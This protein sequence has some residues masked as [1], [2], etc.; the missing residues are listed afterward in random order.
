MGWHGEGAHAAKCGRTDSARVNGP[1][2]PEE[3]PVNAASHLLLFLGQSSALSP[4]GSTPIPQ[5]EEGRRK[6]N[7]QQ[8]V[9]QQ[10]AQQPRGHTQSRPGTG[11]RLLSSFPSGAHPSFPPALLSAAPGNILQHSP[12]SPC[13]PLHLQV[14]PKAWPLPPTLRHPALCV[15][16]LPPHTAHTAVT[17]HMAS[18]SSAQTGHPSGLVPEATSSSWSACPLLAC[19]THLPCSPRFEVFP[20][21]Q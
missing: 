19:T 6:Q 5:N 3:L 17:C 1:E 16:L 9:I 20:W 7:G 18:R 15:M 13:L 4:G 2:R 8:P 21:V 10:E 11:P 14:G 12:D